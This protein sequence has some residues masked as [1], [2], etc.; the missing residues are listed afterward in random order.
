M[1]Y[2]DLGLLNCNHSRGK[3]NIRL[4]ISSSKK[5]MGIW[6]GEDLFW[7]VLQFWLR[8]QSTYIGHKFSF[9]WITN[10]WKVLPAESYLLA[11]MK[12]H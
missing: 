11:H 4:K 12:I 3:Q 6:E 5:R 9:I 10:D 8:I 7:G 1:Q 2:C